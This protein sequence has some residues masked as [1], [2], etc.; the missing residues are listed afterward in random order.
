[1]VSRE[2][3]AKSKVL[4]VGAASLVSAASTYV[5]NIVAARTLPVPET[6]VLLTD[7]AALF[8]FY[9]ILAAVTTEFTRSIAVATRTGVAVGPAAWKVIA[10]IAV[11]AAS[12]L[13]LTSNLWATRGGISLS[14]PVTLL[15][16][17]GVF[18]FAWHAALCGVLAGADRWGTMSRLV[19][20]EGSGRIVF[21]IVV[22]WIGATAD[23]YLG[24]IVAASFVWLLFAALSRTSRDALR[25]RIDAPL[26]V[27]VPRFGAALAAQSASAALTVAFPV[28]LAWTTA[29]SEYAN[30][31]PLLLAIAVTRAPMMLPLTAYQSMIVAHF[32]SA[33]VRVGHDLAAV[34]AGVLGVGAAGAGLAWIIGPPLFTWLISPEY[35]VDGVILAGLTMAAAVLAL[36]TLTGAVAQALSRHGLF[37]AGWLAALAVSV[38]LLLLPGGIEFR[39]GCSLAGGPL[40]AV[41]IHALALRPRRQAPSNDGTTAAEYAPA[42]PQEGE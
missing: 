14:W 40:A 20:S 37:L 24:A 30:S 31:A 21:A 18:G 16:G 28:L 22:M 5:V 36:A 17:V 13:V 11:T 8:F 35:H 12:A 39:A 9:G 7:L 34:A 19:G 32:T 27:Q 1:L 42:P 41:L 10:G 38:S 3:R 23:R 25:L 2:Y 6:T 29:S 26:R 33:K 15:M 4:L